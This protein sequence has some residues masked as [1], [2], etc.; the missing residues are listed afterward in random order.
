MSSSF[1]RW[2]LLLLTLLPGCGGGPAGVAPGGPGGR[3]R[4]ALV[5]VGVVT[6]ES[7]EPSTLAVGTVIAR[8][9]SVVASGA[10]GKVD[11][12][13]VREGDVVEEGQELSIL[14]MVTTNLEIAE[15][16]SMLQERE[17][18]FQASQTS[19]P[20]EIAEAHARMEAAQVTRDVAADRWQ[21]LQRLAQGGA[22]NQDSVDEAR[23]RAEAA[24]KMFIAAQAAHALVAAGPRNEVKLQSQ[25]HRDAQ[26]QR[27]DFLKA[28]REKR[29]TRAPFRGI[30]VAEHTESGQWLSKD[31]DVVTI[32]DLL[33]A[34][35]IIANV[36]QS[37]LGNVQV[38]AQVTVTVEGITP[39]EWTGTVSSVVP[40]SD[41]EAGSR[42]FPVKVTVPNQV[43]EV[44]G[45]TQPVLREGMLARLRFAGPSHEATL[46]P[47]NSLI[48]S[49]TGTRL[50]AVVPGEAP[51]SGKARPIVVQEAGAYGDKVEVL[52]DEVQTDMQVVTEGAERL[53]PFAEIQIQTDAPAGGPAAAAPGR[54]PAAGPPE[55]K[56]AAGPP[57]TTA[58]SKTS[59]PPAAPSAQ[60]QLTS[61]P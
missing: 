48:R 43:V 36:D 53:T 18:E 27:V 1:A 45:R 41:W 24:D 55:G 44:N 28:E 56:P 3:P 5:R 37:E 38:G 4:S 47:K 12:F 10:D 31:A 14:N 60:A 34:V 8:R 9:T 52:G 51:G 33:E 19:R 50:Y 6:R 2:P 39:A 42:M 13:L 49:E 57:S 61:T 7:V 15:A 16:E 23:E 58:P 21:R 29:T 35:D 40:R 32:A 11:R 30:V 17:Q 54:Q 20:E 26:Q 59:E 22:A 25:A 46:V